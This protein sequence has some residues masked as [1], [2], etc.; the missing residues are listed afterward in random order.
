MTKADTT[1]NAPIFG[2]C[3]HAL[4][5]P[6]HPH[7]TGTGRNEVA[8]R[9]RGCAAGRLLPCG[10]FRRA[11]RS[12]DDDDLCVCRVDPAKKHDATPCMQLRW[13]VA[14]W[15]ARPPVPPPL[16]RL[17]DRTHKLA[18]N[19]APFARRRRARREPPGRRGHHHA[20]VGRARGKKEKSRRLVCVC[21]CVCVH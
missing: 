20:G 7:Q 8:H 4:T 3:V 10:G 19:S 21:V 14:S 11:P 1:R 12:E 17:T 6:A 5:T 13:S 18:R 9:P 15:Q 2:L 16:D